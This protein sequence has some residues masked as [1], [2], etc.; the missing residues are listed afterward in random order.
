MNKFL[1][2]TGIFLVL[3]IIL[4]FIYTKVYILIWTDNK[5]NK[6]VALNMR[7]PK[8]FKM[9]MVFSYLYI[10]GLVYIYIYISAD[11]FTTIM[12]STIF[13][14]VLIFLLSMLIT[15]QKKSSP[16]YHNCKKGSLFMLMYPII[17]VVLYIWLKYN[18]F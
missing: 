7:F 15:I 13:G 1:G 12:S 11:D 18:G 6:E 2:Y 17:G 9:L 16:H 5:T 4:L 14:V 8:V 3:Y 10:G